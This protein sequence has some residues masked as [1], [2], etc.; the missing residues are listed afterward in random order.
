MPRV[1]RGATGVVVG[2]ALLTCAVAPVASDSLRAEHAEASAAAIRSCPREYPF[3]PNSGSFPT[4]EEG[5]RVGGMV[6]IVAAYGRQHPESFGSTGLSWSGPGDATVFAAFS[7]DVGAQATA[8]RR[9][10][11]FPAEL[12]VCKAVMSQTESRALADELGPELRTRG[13]GWR[14]ALDGA[15]ELILHDADVRFAADLQRRYGERVRIMIGLFPYP[16][17]NPLPPSQCRSLPDT[18]RA[19]GLT[20]TVDP[21]AEPLY[22]RRPQDAQ[23]AVLRLRNSGSTRLRFETEALVGTLLDPG[24]S[25]EVGG[26]HGVLFASIATDVDVPPGGVA[27]LRVLLGVAACDP[28]RGHVVPPGAYDLVVLLKT[29]DGADPLIS[30]RLPVTVAG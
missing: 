16:M 27:T 4:A 15:V 11:P 2:L 28:S 12:F 25:N 29:L 20:I 3:V 19:P 13:S 22:P 8:L 6:E 9:A 18:R 30:A 24:G 17:P 10:V 5:R 23:H 14:I 21:L 7:R 1:R 26:V